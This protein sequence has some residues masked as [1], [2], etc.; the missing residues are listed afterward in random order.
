M[1]SETRQQQFLDNTIDLIRDLDAA[2]HNYEMYPRTHPLIT[3]TTAQVMKTFEKI[4]REAQGEVTFIN[5][6]MPSAGQL[7][8][9]RLPV[10]STDRPLS[11]DK[12]KE[13]MAAKHILNLTIVRGVNQ[14]ELVSFLELMALS[15]DDRRTRGTLQE[16]LDE[17][18]VFHIKVDSLQLG[19]PLAED[20]F[21]NVSFIN[22]WLWGDDRENYIPR[23]LEQ[24]RQTPER[25]ALNL[26]MAALIEGDFEG[27]SS[28]DN[29]IHALVKKMVIKFGRLVDELFTEE[30]MG[31]H[32]FY[33]GRLLRS[34][35]K[36]LFDTFSLLVFATC[37]D[38]AVGGSFHSELTDSELVNDLIARYCAL[39][40]ENDD[41][42]RLESIL[43]ALYEESRRGDGQVET[44]SLDDAYNTLMDALQL[45]KSRFV[46]CRSRIEDIIQNLTALNEHDKV[47]NLIAAI[48]RLLGEQCA[49][50]ESADSMVTTIQNA[51]GGYLETAGLGQVLMFTR[52]LLAPLGNPELAQRY[53]I[54]LR[55]LILRRIQELL[56]VLNTE[57]E[58]ELST[59]WLQVLDQNL[60]TPRVMYLAVDVV[61]ELGKHYNNTKRWQQVN[62]LNGYLEGLATRPEAAIGVADALMKAGEG[63]IQAPVFMRLITQMVSAKL[64]DRMQAIQ[65]LSEGGPQVLPLILRQLDE[66]NWFLRRNALV[67]V[68]R[69]GIEAE[70]DKAAV[71]TRDDV[72]QVRKQ[73]LKTIGVIAVRVWGEGAVMSASLSRIVLDCLDD[74]HRLVQ[75]EAIKLTGTLVLSGAIISLARL[76]EARLVSFSPKDITIA[77]E[78]ISALVAVAKRAP[79]KEAQ[80]MDPLLRFVGR[81]EGL[82]TRARLTPL[83]AFAIKAMAGLDSDRTMAALDSLK[84]RVPA[85]LRQ[86]ITAAC[87]QRN[88]ARAD[89]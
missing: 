18:H 54:T 44:Q 47:F 3:R 9:N 33:L 5:L 34:V 69:L 61:V 68:E 63:M 75:A 12:F 71:L 31:E 64:S 53:F 22:G 52:E 27:Y 43:A 41:E 51:A 20:D 2:I 29:R 32:I 59:F 89:H 36:R 1:I 55:D 26:S 13:T 60:G 40:E 4:I 10:R 46:V 16:L 38:D 49:V 81:R 37:S 30:T 14:E 6:C 45:I 72:W 56:P 25:L 76:F 70:L 80:A 83:K 19:G 35:D 66:D 77:Q 15:A 84:G 39:R 65:Q 21:L 67:L 86:Q 74:P 7:H 28:F 85:D 58:E 78:L 11:L 23:F 17:A 24:L 57:E 8:C 42:T 79:H 73:A 88:Q 82:F 87:R 62:E 50:E 48:L